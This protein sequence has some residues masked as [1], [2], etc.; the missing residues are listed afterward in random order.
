V[1]GVSVDATASLKAFTENNKIHHPLLSDFG[2]QMLP[3]YGAM[4]TNENSP[5]Y[6][7]AKRAYFILDKQG[8]IRFMRVDDNPLDILTSNEVLKAI[9]ESGV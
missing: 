2:R 3:A 1:V 7:Y 6:R 4:V 9:K 5:V 8:I